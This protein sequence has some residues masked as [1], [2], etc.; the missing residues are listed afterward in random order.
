MTCHERTEGVRG[1][2]LPIHNIG[3]RSGWVL[4]A[5]PRPLYS[6]EKDQVRILRHG[7]I[8]LFYGTPLYSLTGTEVTYGNLLFRA[9]CDRC[10]LPMSPPHPPV[11]KS[12]ATRANFLFSFRHK[13]SAVLMARTVTLLIAH[14]LAV[15][16]AR[17][18]ALWIW[19]WIH[20]S[21]SASDTGLQITLWNKYKIK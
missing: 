11:Y 9:V 21:R 10:P 16:E 6:R 2:A 5:T 18:T 7:T 4:T 1:I 17:P 15:P 3:A 8:I 20:V 13:A 12:D 14:L 19:V